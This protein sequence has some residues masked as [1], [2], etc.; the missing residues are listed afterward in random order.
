[1]AQWISLLPYVLMVPGMGLCLYLFC[2]LKGEIRR[3]ERKLAAAQAAERKLTPPPPPPPPVPARS[4]GIDLTRRAQALRMDRRGE[5]PA[6]IAAALGVPRNEIDLMLK[7]QQ[8]VAG[9]ATRKP[10]VQAVAAGSVQAN[11]AG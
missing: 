3:L 2:T 6:T 4:C 11:G 5:P 7:V 9:E 8:L 1:M 10:A